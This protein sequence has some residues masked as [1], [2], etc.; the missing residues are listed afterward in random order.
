MIDRSLRFVSVSRMAS[1]RLIAPPASGTVARQE[2]GASLARDRLAATLSRRRTEPAHACGD[3]EPAVVD[4]DLLVG[5]VVGER[6]GRSHGH[7]CHTLKRAVGDPDPLLD[8]CG[9]R[10]SRW[11]RKQDHAI[12]EQPGV[13]DLARSRLRASAKAVVGAPL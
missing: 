7:R 13:R 8:V 12:G 2:R 4:H 3:L 11:L 5:G 1:S 6:D 9:Q 10:R